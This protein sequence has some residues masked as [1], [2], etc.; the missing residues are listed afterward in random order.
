MT[1][2]NKGNMALVI[3]L[4]I[5]LL[6]GWSDAYPSEHD[7]DTITTEKDLLI[8]YTR[9]VEVHHATSSNNKN[10]NVLYMKR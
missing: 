3:L 6:L 4:I 10:T 5:L 2:T 8:R 1:T 7:D 9:T